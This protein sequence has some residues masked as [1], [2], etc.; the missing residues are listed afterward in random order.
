MLP[1]SGPPGSVFRIALGG[2][3]PNSPAHIALYRGEQE[4]FRYATTFGMRVNG[5]GE[6]MYG[7]HTHADDPRGE[8]LLALSPPHVP[9]LF[10]KPGYDVM[11][12]DVA[13]FT[14]GIDQPTPVPTATAGR[15]PR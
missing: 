11:K 7:L 12:P 8:Y 15:S 10:D 4:G 2:F 5:R 9:M 14:V 3:P 1:S 6:T 13:L